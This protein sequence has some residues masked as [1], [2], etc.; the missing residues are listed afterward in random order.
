L[1][2]C[3]EVV[4]DDGV[5]LVFGLEEVVDLCGGGYALLVNWLVVV[6]LVEV[7]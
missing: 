3:W 6:K 1:L 2:H 4:L 7:C 5:V